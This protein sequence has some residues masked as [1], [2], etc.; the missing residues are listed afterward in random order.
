MSGFL[1]KDWAV[2]AGTLIAIPLLA[3]LVGQQ[4]AGYTL[5]VFGGLAFLF[6]IVEAMRSEK[7]ERE[8]MF[9]VLILMFFSM[10]FWAFFEQGGSSIN[11]FTDRN[12]DR[13]FEAQVISKD[14]VGKTMEITL[15]QEQFG[16]TMGEKLVTLTTVE[17]AASS[18]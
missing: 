18:R 5:S 9:V 14:D 2:Y 15:N 11:N 12:V 17:R 8:R 4:L 1:R 7:V 6:L 16:R 10:L 3:L 13:V